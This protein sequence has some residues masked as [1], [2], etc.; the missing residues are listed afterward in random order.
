MK[1]VFPGNV[2]PWEKLGPPVEHAKGYGLKIMR[3]HFRRPD[4]V[5]DDF[6]HLT[7]STGVTV[8]AVT[9]QGEIIL[10]EEY[11]QGT[12]RLCLE[13]ASAVTK[14]G[15]DPADTAR[16]EFR[17][18]TG[19]RPGRLFEVPGGPFFFGERKFPFGYHLF[20]ACDCVRVGDPTPE[21]GEVAFNV[22]LATP[23]EFWQE[24]A[25]RRISACQTVHGAHASVAYGLIAS[26][27]SL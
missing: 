21:A 20:L 12:D 5:E 16:R 19:F 4:Q 13:A 14:K 24:V 17:E 2:Q 7:G 22:Y 10:K 6:D 18:E 11:K 23:G 1:L 26:P 25:A 15:E 9:D 8:F 3:Q 27:A